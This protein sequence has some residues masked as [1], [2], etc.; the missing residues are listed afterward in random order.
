M[1]AGARPI[2]G[3]STGGA[4]AKYAAERARIRPRR[5][6]EYWSIGVMRDLGIAASDRGV[7]AA[8]RPAECARL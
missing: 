3:N 8:E 5:V 2:F 1:S 6:V 7:G 4:L